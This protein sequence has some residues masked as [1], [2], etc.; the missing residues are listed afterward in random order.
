MSE[1]RQYLVI[2]ATNLQTLCAMVD[3][4]LANGCELVG[5][6]VVDLTQMAEEE[7]KVYRQAM[8][9]VME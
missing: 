3:D 4:H 6:L 9:E 2:S 1:K 8:I 7:G 5:G